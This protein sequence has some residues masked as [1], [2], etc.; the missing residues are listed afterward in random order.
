MNIKWRKHPEEKPEK[1]RPVLMEYS[2]SE[3]GVVVAW[4]DPDLKHD[5]WWTDNH[6]CGCY[7]SFYV[8]LTYSFK[9]VYISE[10]KQELTEKGIG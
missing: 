8:G 7:D 10:I 4:I 6:G 5:S 9:W 3:Y 1:G 2:A